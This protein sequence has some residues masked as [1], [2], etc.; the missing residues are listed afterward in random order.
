MVLEEFKT[1]H[2]RLNSKSQV[3]DVNDGLKNDYI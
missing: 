1:H 3:N 2:S